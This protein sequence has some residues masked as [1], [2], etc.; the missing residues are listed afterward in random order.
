MIKKIITGLQTLGRS[1]QLWGYLISVAVAMVLAIAFFHPDAFEGNTL[2][3]GDL[4][5][6]AANGR[7]VQLYREATGEQSRWTNALFSGMPTFQISPTYPSDSLFKWIDTAMR[8]GLPDPSGLLFSMMLGFI[9][10]GACLRWKW[11]YTLIGAVAWGFSSYFIIIIGAGHLWKFITLTYVPPV[12][13][14]VIAAYRGRWLAGSAVAALFAMMQIASNHIQMTYYFLFL[15]VGIVVAF[16]I[17]GIWVNDLRKWLAAT[18]ALAVAAVLAVAANSPSL[19]NTYKYSKETI[20]GQHSMLSAAADESPQQGLDKDY[21]TQYSYGRSESFT[22]LIPNVKGG[23]SAKPVN[24]RMQMLTLGQLPEAEKIA[25]GTELDQMGRQYIDNYVTQYFGEPESTNGPVYVG[26]VVCALFLLGCF[27]VRGPVKWA[28]LV[29]TVLSVLLAMG[30]NCMWLTDFF[31]DNVPMYRNF[32]TPESILVIAEFTMPFLA[33]LAMAKIFNG[34]KAQREYRAPIA[35]AFAIPAFF[36]FIGW[37]FPGVYGEAVTQTDHQTSQM[38][39][40]QLSMNGYPEEVVK[41]FSIDN[42][43]IYNAVTQ[44]RQSMVSADSLRSLLFIAIAFVAIWLLSIKVI[45][46]WVAVAAI[47]VL[48]L[49]D[50]YAADKRYISHESF[51]AAQ[52]GGTDA[53]FPLSDTDRTILADTTL[54]FRVMDIPDFWTAAPSYRHRTIGGY[55]AAKLTRYQDL[56][57]RHLGHFTQG[58]ASEAD[59]NIL[60]MLNAKYVIGPDGQLSVNT[61]A[62]GNAWFVEDIRW[63]N[64]DNAEMDALDTFNPSTTAIISESF[65]QEVKV[66][67]PVTRG[68]TIYLTSYAPDKLTYR[69]RAAGEA[70]AV[71]SEVYFPWGWK[72]TVDGN[73]MPIVRANY[74]LRAMNLPAGEHTIVMTFDPPTVHTAVTWAYISIILIYLLALAAI[75]AALYRRG[76]RAEEKQ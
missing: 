5:Q 14:G 30:R 66:P 58:Q 43:V 34:E 8:G 33:V 22:L 7:E 31:I 3:Q 50:L 15:I 10:M 69:Y 12:V 48:I 44:L 52:T 32:R 2:N 19:Y 18:G 45:P 9:I 42:P 29:L 38:L 11:Q 26:A 20:R 27:I 46:R 24:G 70:L 23:A 71:F 56:I 53:R 35:W 37:L 55:H 6:G 67:A 40:Y 64:G 17:K 36:C 65:N 73:E 49:G 1:R 54:H 28:F 47:G 68:D 51:T 16:L 60:D 25:G 75:C 72:A 62:L 74:V 59:W 41:Y 63:V 21:I 39:G 13:G 4:Q 61:H 57:D 76:N